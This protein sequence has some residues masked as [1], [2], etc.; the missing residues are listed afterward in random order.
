[1]ADAGSTVAFGRAAV[2]FQVH[3]SDFLVLLQDRITTFEAMA[4][5]FP[6]ATDF[7]EYLKKVVRSKAGYREAD[8]TATTY[9]KERPLQWEEFKH[10]E[11]TGCL[12]KLWG[13]ATQI[14]KKQLERLAGDD[15]ETKVKVTLSLSQE[16]EDRAVA[17]GMPD[18]HSDRERPSLHTLSKVQSTFGTGGSFQHIPWESFVSMEVESRL[19]RAGKLPRDKRELVVEE[20]KISLNSR[21]EEFPEAPVIDTVLALQDT[22]S[23]RARAFQMLDVCPY[24]VVMEYSERLVAKLRVTTPEGMRAPTINEARRCDREILTEICSWVAKGRG[25]I[26]AGLSFYAAEGD[27]PLWRLMDLH[28]EHHPDQGREKGSTRSGADPTGRGVKRALEDEDPKEKPDPARARMCIVCG[29]R[30]E[31]RCKIPPGFR[32]ELKTKQKEK[33][34]RAEAEKKKKSSDPAR[35]E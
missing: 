35:K 6:S 10:H 34:Q 22:L 4:Y 9:A 11:D 32:K 19:R 13:L 7:E 30:H 31:P 23:L 26:E 16:M 25:S 15:S 17:A 18:P 12:R 5:R 33:K 21:D 20:K 29:T 1:M 24:G 3:E 28:P 27:E 2:Q 14:A 8:G